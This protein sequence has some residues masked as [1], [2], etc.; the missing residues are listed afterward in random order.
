MSVLFYIREPFLPLKGSA[1]FRINT[2]TGRFN[3]C[4]RIFLVPQNQEE[5]LLKKKYRGCYVYKTNTPIP[6]FSY[7]YKPMLVLS[8]GAESILIMRRILQAHRIKVIYGFGSIAAIIGHLDS[9]RTPLV[10]DL[11]ETDLPYVRWE[12]RKILRPLSIY[13]ENLLFHWLDTVNEI[14]VLTNAMKEYI[15]S[16][17]ANPK[18]VHVVYDGTDPNL[19]KPQDFK[20]KK[21]NPA[22]VFTG[23]LDRRDGVDNLIRGFAKVIKESKTAKLYIIGDGPLLPQL[24]KLTFKLKLNRNV[25]F[26]GWIPF[27][28]L[29]MALPSFTVGVIPSKPCLLNDIVIPRKTF[30]F[31]A[32]GL[33]VVASDL[34]AMREIIE[35][36]TSGILI[37]PEDQDALCEGILKLITD[38][39]LYE[40]IQ[41]NGRRIAEKYSADNEVAKIEELMRK[42]F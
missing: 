17:G 10:L 41:Q 29:V 25:I 33:P 34:K 37:K 5:E 12:D 27:S 22:V 40:K 26:T 14:V 39:E 35:S 32:A 9:R 13:G 42:Y 4:Q 28:K 3:D 8:F 20:A 1:G 11:F 24:V 21:D 38:E 15:V 23:D 19:F 36:G 16:R 2:L 30:E 7:T 6:R 18:S 31:M